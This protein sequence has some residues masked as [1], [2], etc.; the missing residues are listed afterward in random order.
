MAP[1]GAVA[2]DG[3]MTGHQWTRRAAIGLGLAGALALGACGKI[4]MTVDTPKNGEKVLLELNQPMQVRWGN[5]WPQKGEWTLEKAP[6]AGV[7]S[8]GTRTVQPPANG[9]QQLEVFDFT[10]A[11]KGR[12]DVTFI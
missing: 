10:A 12:D 4:P 11:K 7:V 6:P 1:L 8:V 9:A 3:H 2:E 5:L